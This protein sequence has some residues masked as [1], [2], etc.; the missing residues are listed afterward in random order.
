MDYFP[1]RSPEGTSFRAVSIH[2]RK[3]R[4]HL[5]RGSPAHICAVGR[6]SGHELGTSKRALVCSAAAHRPLQLLL[7]GARVGRG[8]DGGTTRRLYVIH[9]DGRLRTRGSLIN[10]PRVLART[11]ECVPAQPRQESGFE[12]RGS[13]A[14]SQSMRGGR[15]PLAHSARDKISPV[16]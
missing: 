3:S 7:L 1:V 14:R 16:H 4:T 10:D 6:H 13:A 2:N 5:C 9:V 15:V 12:D 11:Y 8:Q